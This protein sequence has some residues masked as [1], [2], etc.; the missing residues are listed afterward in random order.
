MA[1]QV[2]R[3]AGRRL[4]RL[5]EQCHFG[6]A[7]GFVVR[8]DVATVGPG[9]E[10]LEPARGGTPRH[11]EGG[12]SVPPLL[13]NPTRGGITTP[14]PPRSSFALFTVS[15]L[16]PTFPRLLNAQRQIRRITP[17]QSPSRSFATTHSP[18]EP[19]HYQTM[20]LPF[21]CP[22]SAVKARYLELVKELHPDSHPSTLSE[23][24]KRW[25]SERFV[26]VQHAYE[27]LGSES[28]RKQ[29]DRWLVSQTTQIRLGR[30]TYPYSASSTTPGSHYPRHST[31]RPG[32][33][34]NPYIYE[35]VTDPHDRTNFSTWYTS[36][37]HPPATG[38]SD[39][40]LYGMIIV[41][42]CIGFFIQLARVSHFE[43]GLRGRLDARD[44]QLGR[45]WTDSKVGAK[46]VGDVVKKWE[47]KNGDRP[48]SQGE[49]S[50]GE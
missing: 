15:S 37:A 43:R 2:Q 18:T 28:K 34:N 24:D 38:I 8:R 20:S 6:G 35:T 12:T 36:R 5:F 16:Y 21:N 39:H 10:P 17:L 47:G 42:V 9:L 33:R 4:A 25:R 30:A 44:R 11:L 26:R 48:V 7:T 14:N 3:Q 41:L 40:V 22:L 23:G 49:V 45:A 46:K 50:S 31:S 13:P 32:S 29:Y 19:S 1:G 27:V